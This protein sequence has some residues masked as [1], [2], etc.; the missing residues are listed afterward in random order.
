MI[1]AH[2]QKCWPYELPL[3]AFGELVGAIKPFDAHP[4]LRTEVVWAALHG[5]AV[6]RRGGRIPADAQEA[7][8]DLLVSQISEAGSLRA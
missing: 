3:K 4:E 7:R 5:L 2:M 8:I 6:L 1:L